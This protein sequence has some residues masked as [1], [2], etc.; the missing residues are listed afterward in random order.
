MMNLLIIR[1]RVAS[2]KLSPYDQAQREQRIIDYRAAGMTLDQI[3]VL[4]NYSSVQAVSRALNDAYAKIPA[5]TVKQ[6]RA[7]SD[8]TN[9]LSRRHLMNIINN[10]PLKT[11]AIGKTV[12]DPRTGEYVIDEAR[13]VAAIDCLRKLDNSRRQ[14]WGVDRAPAVSEEDAMVIAEQ[15]LR[16]L[17]QRLSETTTVQATVVRE[18]PQGDDDDR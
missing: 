8:A 18:L 9:D 5:P 11:T 10:P 12:I 13:R 16:D 17:D 4:E 15:F 7:Q 2:K 14:L 3:M 1:R 6:L